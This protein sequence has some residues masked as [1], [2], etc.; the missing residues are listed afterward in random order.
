[1]RFLLILLMGGCLSGCISEDANH[2]ERQKEM[3]EWAAKLA[4]DHDAAWV[5]ELNGRGVG[6]VGMKNDFYIDT[7]IDGSITIHG[8]ANRD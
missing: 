6:S 2:W 8:R 1:M 5:I 4:D 3:L 7:G